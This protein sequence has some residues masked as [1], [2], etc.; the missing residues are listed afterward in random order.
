VHE[1]V[2]HGDHYLLDGQWLLVCWP[3]CEEAQVMCEVL[4]LV[5]S[6]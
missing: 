2:T 4:E 3:L 1:L 5:I 6:G